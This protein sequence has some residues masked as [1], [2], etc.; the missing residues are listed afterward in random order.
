MV[1]EEHAIQTDLFVYT[2]FYHTVE[3]E[4][5]LQMDFLVY[6]RFY[7]MLEEEH[8][9]QTDLFTL[10]CTTRLRKSM[11]FRQFSGLY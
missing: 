5:A 10:D 9:I 3:E 6:S 11:R 8:A 4:H 7:Y 1:E 2:R